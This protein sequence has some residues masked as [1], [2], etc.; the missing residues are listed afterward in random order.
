MKLHFPKEIRQ[1]TLMDCSRTHVGKECRR[2]ELLRFRHVF[3]IVA[4]F[5]NLPTAFIVEVTMTK[6]QKCNGIN[7][8]FNI[9]NDKSIYFVLRLI[10]LFS[11]GYMDKESNGHRLS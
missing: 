10:A 1:L 11:R 5:I 2:E 6:G 9:A 4:G 7:T 8:L 3:Y